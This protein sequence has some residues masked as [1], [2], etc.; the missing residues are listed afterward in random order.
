MT[1]IPPVEHPA[2]DAEQ[3]KEPEYDGGRD[4]V[5]Y[6]RGAVDLDPQQ[7]PAQR[8]TRNPKMPAAILFKP[9]RMMTLS[10]T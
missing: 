7:E 1:P 10:G 2:A 3:K 5:P 9:A 8:R 4:T 6:R